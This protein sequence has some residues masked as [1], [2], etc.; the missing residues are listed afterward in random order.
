M[1]TVREITPGG[2]AEDWG[3]VYTALI[4][5]GVDPDHARDIVV[6]MIHAK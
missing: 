4:T 2:V 3:D 1:V 6:A 5:K